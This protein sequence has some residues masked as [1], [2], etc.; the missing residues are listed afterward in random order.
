MTK[1]LA[2]ALCLSLL[3]VPQIAR[4]QEPVDYSKLTARPSHPWVHD[5]VIYE[6]FPRVFSKEGNF[7][8]VTAQLDRLDTLGVTVLW[9]MPIHPIGEVKRKGTYGSPYAVK[10]FYAIDPSLGTKEDLKELVKGAHAREMKVIID[11]VANHTAWDSVMMK[12]PSFYTKD[13]AGRIVSPVPDWSDVAD[14]DYGNPELRKYMTEMLKYWIREFDLD[15]FRCD[16]AGFVP[17]DF[18]EN[19]R[20]EL[21]QVK[22]DIVLLAEWHEPELLVNAFDLDYAWPMHRAID[23]V[24]TGESPAWRLRETWREERERF[25]KNALHM[26]ILDNHDE[27]RA[28]AR[29]GEHGTLAGAAFIFTIDGVPLVYNGMEVG[30]TAESGAPALF[31]R[32]P[33]LWQIAERRPHFPRFYERMIDLREKHG[34]LRRGEVEWIRNSNETNLVTFIRR[35]ATEE[36]LV[37]I[38]MSGQRVPGLVDLANGGQFEEITPSLEEP[39]A[40]KRASSLPGLVLDPWEFRIYR[41]AVTATASRGGE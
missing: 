8:G 25:P 13:A 37:A 34:A 9:L 2:L 12:N 15:G 40:Q 11:V 7:D 16:V 4:A 33:I 39:P 19:L 35:D 23:A 18:W 36:I 24:L 30:D 3:V 32:I 26:R 5:A 31:E 10:D 28:I 41:R 29:F 1:R 6:I 27:R 38:N 22:P 21:E 20:K 17:T 14:L